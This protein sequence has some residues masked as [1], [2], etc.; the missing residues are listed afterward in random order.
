LIRE[1][2]RAPRGEK[3]CGEVSGK[4]FDRHNIVSALNLCKPVAAFGFK[5]SCDSVLFETWVEQVLV[6]EL[7]PGD[8]VIAD[9]AKFHKSEKTRKLIENAGCR[10]VFLPPYSPDLNPIE[11]FWD[12]MKNKIKEIVHM[13]ETL[14]LAIMAAVS[15][16]QP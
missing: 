14:E 5:G 6:T 3:V 2:G 13:F 12:W 8:V 16:K 10:L 4:R 9:N 15:A 1:Y 7:S 11:H